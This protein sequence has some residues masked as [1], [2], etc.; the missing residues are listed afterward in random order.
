MPREGVAAGATFL[1]VKL[2][3][4]RCGSASGRQ[5]LAVGTDGDVPRA[6]VPR[7]ALQNRS[8]AVTDS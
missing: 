8:C 2:R 1:H 5:P 6:D 7:D 3:A 4:F